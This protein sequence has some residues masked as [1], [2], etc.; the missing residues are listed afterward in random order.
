MET[1]QILSFLFL[2]KIFNQPD[3]MDMY[4]VREQ[5]YEKLKFNK[6]M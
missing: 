5:N 1:Y 6:I 4:Q 3:L 2:T